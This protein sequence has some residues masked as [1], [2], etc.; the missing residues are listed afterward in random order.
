MSFSN[1]VITLSNMM[2]LTHGLRRSL[3]N[4]LALIYFLSLDFDI[5]AVTT[6][7][8]A[9]TLIMT[10]FEFP[11]GALADYDS[12]KKSLFISF[13]LMGIS[14]SGIFVFDQFW[15]LACFWILGDIAFT[16]STGARSAWAIDAL[17]AAKDKIVILKLGS[18]AAFHERLGQVVGGMA[19]LALVLIDLRFVWLLIAMTNFAMAYIIWHHV[20]ERYFKPEKLPTHWLIKVISKAKE[21]YVYILSKSNRTLRLYMLIEALGTISSSAFLL[22][23][24]LLLTQHLGLDK[25]FLPLLYGSVMFMTL[26][27]PW[28]AQRYMANF[29]LK[30]TLWLLGTLTGSVML[31]LGLVESILL[32]VLAVAIINFVNTG[33][34]VLGY[35]AMELKFS[36]KI[37]ASLGSINSINWSVNNAVAV[38][39]AG[40]GITYFGVASVIVIA[41]VIALIASAMYL[42]SESSSVDE[43]KYGKRK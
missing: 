16:F 43:V 5:V 27:A 20:E 26:A 42:L 22:A 23:L 14:F 9:S 31:A 36:S 19:G 18:Q 40:L 3:V 37:R 13:F 24:P 1:K 21:S 8:A 6:L 25:Q 41:G 39:L 12:R 11:T 15:V 34:D 10:L 4:A 30:I 32:A 35:A 2:E 7:F 28:L 29:D 38:F 33:S 17:R